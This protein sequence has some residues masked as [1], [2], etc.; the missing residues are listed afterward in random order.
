MPAGPQGSERPD[1][2]AAGGVLPSFGVIAA[3][4]E[5]CCGFS[6]FATD[7]GGVIKLWSEGAGRLNGYARSEIVG[8]PMRKLDSD[9]DS[10]PGVSQEILD[11]TLR[12]GSWEGPVRRRRRDG[13]RFTAH[14]WVTP[15]R[16]GDDSPAGFLFVSRD[17]SGEELLRDALDLERRSRRVL[18]DASADAMVT[19]DAAGVIR[20]A[21]AAAE[22]LFGYGQAELVGR[23]VE[24]LMP[25]GVRDGH[26]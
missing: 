17:I 11:T 4:V 18:F 21:N 7:L 19:A 26:A 20:R 15:F 13:G 8:Q 1:A 6:V 22:R 10:L 14:V 25:A 23:P 5:L 24:M 12:V 2:E 3:A 9:E 16:E